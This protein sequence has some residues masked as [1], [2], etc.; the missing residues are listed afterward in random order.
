MRGGASGDACVTLENDRV[1]L[2]ESDDPSQKIVECGIE[3]DLCVISVGLSRRNQKTS[4]DKRLT[5]EGAV[6]EEIHLLRMD[7]RMRG[8]DR[9]RQTATKVNTKHLQLLGISNIDKGARLV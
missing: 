4:H 5:L 6:D 1:G 9:C 8:R 3:Y 2:Q 7:A